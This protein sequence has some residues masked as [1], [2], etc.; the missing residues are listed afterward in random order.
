M[1]QLACQ[2]R[3]LMFPAAETYFH[4]TRRIS[5]EVIGIEPLR[6]NIDKNFDIIFFLYRHT[7]T[8]TLYIYSKDTRLFGCVARSVKFLRQK[9]IDFVLRLYTFQKGVGVACLNM[10]NGI[11]H[12]LFI[13]SLGR[14]VIKQFIW[15]LDIV[16]LQMVNPVE[17][18]VRIDKSKSLPTAIAQI[19]LCEII[20]QCRTCLTDG[21]CIVKIALTQPGKLLFN[22]FNIQP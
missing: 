16:F 8:G 15:R 19:S 2:Q 18:L 17:H 9:V 14:N 10:I 4:F 3:C 13:G 5:P 1:T 12:K 22:F 20:L 11:C 21:M 6:R 7:P